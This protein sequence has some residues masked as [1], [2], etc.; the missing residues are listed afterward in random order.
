MPDIETQGLGPKWLAGWLVGCLDGWLPGWLAGWLVGWLA[1][2]VGG[3]LSG[4]LVGWLVGWLAGCRL[5][6][7]S[8]FWAPPIPPSPYH[9]TGGFIGKYINI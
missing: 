3:W 9:P 2:W 7:I 4:W 8:T 5:D 1:G 6:G